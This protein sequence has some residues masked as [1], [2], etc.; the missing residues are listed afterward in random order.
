[1]SAVVERGSMAHYIYIVFLRMRL[2]LSKLENYE[3]IAKMRH[4]IHRRVC[5][6][7]CWLWCCGHQ[8]DFRRGGQPCGRCRYVWAGHHGYDLCYRPHFW[9]AFQPG[10]DP[11]F[12]LDAAF[13]QRE[14]APYIL[15]QCAGA[16]VASYIH[17]ASLSSVLAA[18]QPGQVLNLGV[19]LPV[20]GSFATALV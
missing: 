11:C 2:L 8:S 5:H 9:G 6:C 1:M 19:S 16:V 20:D 3:S 4:R 17:V 7:F 12:Y 14:I 18:T 10:G 13:S 15:A